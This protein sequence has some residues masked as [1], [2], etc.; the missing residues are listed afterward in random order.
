MASIPFVTMTQQIYVLEQSKPEQR[1]NEMQVALHMLQR[2][3]CADGKPMITD[4]VLHLAQALLITG[5]NSVPSIE[6]LQKTIRRAKNVAEYL[7]EPMIQLL[8]S[9]ILVD[10]GEAQTSKLSR[11]SASSSD[12]EAEEEQFK[13][14]P[15]RTVAQEVAT[16]ANFQ[17]MEQ[18]LNHF[19]YVNG[20]STQTSEV[21]KIWESN[22]MLITEKFTLAHFTA[23]VQHYENLKHSRRVQARAAN[24]IHQAVDPKIHGEIFKS[25]GAGLIDIQ[26]SLA[27]KDLYIAIYGKKETAIDEQT[28][29]LQHVIGTFRFDSG[30]GVDWK[31]KVTRNF[32]A[33]QLLEIMYGD[34][35][36]T[37][38]TAS[39]LRRFLIQHVNTL[40]SALAVQWNIE[41]RS[42]P[43]ACM[44]DWLMDK[45]V[46]RQ[47]SS[48]SLR[49]ATVHGK[50]RKESAT[51]HHAQ[52]GQTQCYFCSM[53]H[54]IK[55]CPKINELQNL[56]ARFTGQ[57]MP[58]GGTSA[59]QSHAGIQRDSTDSTTRNKIP[60]CLFCH[61]LEKISANTHHSAE[62]RS[63][64]L[65]I[66]EMENPARAAEFNKR[67]AE[68]IKLQRDSMVGGSRSSPPKSTE[69]HSVRSANRGETREACQICCFAGRDSGHDFRQCPYVQGTVTAKPQNSDLQQLKREA[70]ENNPS[71]RS[72]SRTAH[73]AFQQTPN[74][75]LLRPSGNI[76]YYTEKG[77][78]YVFDGPLES[79]CIPTAEEPERRIAMTATAF[80]ADYVESD[81]DRHEIANAAFEDLPLE[82]LQHFATSQPDP[83]S[84]HNAVLQDIV[85]SAENIFSARNQS[86]AILV[87]AV[88]GILGHVYDKE[89]CLMN[90]LC[91]S[92]ELKIPP[93]SLRRQFLDAARDSPESL[94]GLETARELILQEFDTD[95]FDDTATAEFTDKYIAGKFE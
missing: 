59:K 31:Q 79:G 89:Q 46:E 16:K 57:K 40:D 19:Q 29:H 50:N 2:T 1:R 73:A 55:D 48:L 22:M 78:H 45:M 9:K 23:L 47:E 7:K 72:D 18:I 33:L 11:K 81:H 17:S 65:Y 30:D 20:G 27:I 34:H 4:S 36:S 66:R 6:T 44:Y 67:H 10:D 91:N 43:S 75:D 86:E 92:L 64:A 14:S 87:D 13:A 63:R 53:N 15:A 76:L 77:Q 93:S 84:K 49:P 62:C 95:I 5:V 41:I 60:T 3:T 80:C 68:F 25:D 56:Q 37:T 85:K 70:L 74:L 24:A 38:F 54:H 88:T 26:G 94:L 69:Q 32:E 90:T 52:S 82:I 51:A 12:S 71:M 83:S 28:R 21:D 8:K 39:D 58:G 42:N 61:A 35:C